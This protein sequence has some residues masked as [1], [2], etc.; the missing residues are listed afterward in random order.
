[1]ANKNI[2]GLT[3]EIGADTT[4]LG[5]ALA[6]IDKKSR[7]LSSEL[8]QINKLLKLDPGNTELLAQKQKVLGDAVS[9][10]RERLDKLKEAEKQVQEQFERGEV[11]EEQ[12][13]A[14]QREIIE[15]ERK[16][17]SYEKAAEETADT[18]KELGNNSDK[19]GDDV[20]GLRKD[21]K[22][23][24]DESEKSEKDVEG[25]GEG[26]SEA[27]LQ[28][29]GATV[30]AAAL[31]A[32][33]VAMGRAAIDAFNEVDEGADNVVKATG[34]TGEQ[35]A[36]LVDAY[37]KV[38]S[39]VVGSFDDIGATVG[40][41]NT[42]FGYTGKALEE[43]AT[44]FMKFAEVTGVN[45]TDAVK[46]VSRAMKD[47]GIPLEEYGSLLDQLAK[48]GQAAGIDVTTLADGLSKNGATMRAMGLDT[49]DSIA[50][51]AQFELS[52]A[53]A[54]TMLGGMKKA[55]GTWA[56]AGKDSRA[57]FEKTVKG[58][59]DGSITASDA[60][61]I[62]GAKAGP[63]LVDAIQTGKFEYEDM[64]KVIKSSEGTLE[65]T[66]D[67]LEDGG[68]SVER[69]FQKMKLKAAAMGE[70]IMEQTAP[71]L[72]DMFE[73]MEDSGVVEDLTNFIGKK[74]IPALTNT[75]R[76]VRNNGPIIKSTLVGVATALVAYKTATIAAEVAQKGLKGAIMATEA[77]Q[78]LLNI[79]Q[80]ATP[81]GL[82]AVA[83]T[84]VTAALLAY[85][86]AAAEASV[87]VNILTEEEKELATKADEAAEAFREQKKAT[88]EALADVTAEV[89]HVESLKN[90]LL[91][92]ASA[93][94]YVKEKDQERVNF[95]LNELNEAL[96]TE[97]TMVD[98][99]IQQYGRLKRSIDDVIQSKLANA[100]LETAEADYITAQQNKTKAL[101]NLMLKE[102][103]YRAQQDAYSQYYQEYLEE[104]ARLEKKYQ[105]EVKTGGYEAAAW[106]DME[107]TKL[108]SNKNRELG[109]LNEKKEA[110]NQ[111][112]AW[113]G[114]YSETIM[115]YE[116]AQTAALSGNYDRAVEILQRKGGHFH[117][118]SDEV[119]EATRK[120]VDALYQ[121][122]IDAG[123]EAE[124]TKKNF[125]DGVEG[126]TMEMVKEAERSYQDALDAYATAYADAEGIGEDLGDGLSNG[127]ETKRWGLISKA[128]SLVSGI[129]AAMKN[130]ADSHSPSKKTMNFGEDLGEG[131]EIGIEKK[132]KDVAKAATRQVGAV[133]DAYRLDQLETGQMAA[134]SLTESQTAHQV[135]DRMAA[136]S[137]NTEKLDAILKAIKDGQVLTIDGNV[138][139]GATA[140]K[141][142]SALGQRRAL[143]ARGAI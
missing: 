79:A 117:E 118:Y 121:E 139:V 80:A 108:E 10:T 49:A 11:S 60:L 16:M 78:K 46:A 13:R 34:A 44:D 132:T 35:A 84:G 8:G 105:E 29:D 4:K 64:V 20:D 93:S 76:W 119:D 72:E 73:I 45:S 122:A 21:V 116:E 6:D 130:E 22:D 27:S 109:F 88:D 133:L 51:L 128:K 135:A 41:V 74:L 136:A 90:E 77:A 102:K 18:I 120:A 47:S 15:T 56:K 89:G 113:Y 12:V 58:I 106:T 75:G 137:L 140:E 65:N 131:A 52:G 32:A 38:A 31:T 100:L 26:T 67:E 94:G 91:K 42:R 69:T 129:I 123:L 57:E 37:E 43:C 92:L 62:F 17:N 125:T 98:G 7:D 127:M 9:N 101:E 3:V 87:E 70:E 25:L 141:M 55:M 104:K 66:F 126:Y 19:A 138:L 82:V 95:I 97:Y 61:E 2:K 96:G 48:A 85:N 1:M 110:Y 53:D 103:E 143:V 107:L 40:E 134:R 68:Y 111:A 71:A 142:D 63:Q 115:N 112:A 39:N 54:A 23:L 50:L 33:F 114:T 83:I 81:Y 24:G 59:K 86:S 36:E 124:R 99:V 14:L 30:A 28:F 5:D